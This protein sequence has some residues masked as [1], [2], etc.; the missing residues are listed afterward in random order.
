MINKVRLEA[1]KTIQ[2][3]KTLFENFIS[4]SLLQG[5]DYIFPLIT[6]PYLVR[7]L[8]PEKYGLT[9]FAA[10]LAGYFMIITNYGFNYSAVRDIAIIREDEKKNQWF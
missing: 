3:N 9:A 6:L 10:A 5:L 7:V 8:G 1:R 2:K 4:L